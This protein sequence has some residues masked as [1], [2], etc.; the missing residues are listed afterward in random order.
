[1]DV[2]SSERWISALFTGVK[3]FV[4]NFKADER[5]LSIKVNV[6][7]PPKR[8]FL[9]ESKPLRG[10]AHLYAARVV[11]KWNY[12]RK[13]GNQIR[14]RLLFHRY[15]I[16]QPSKGIIPNHKSFLSG[17]CLISFMPEREWG[18]F[19]KSMTISMWSSFLSSAPGLPVPVSLL[20]WSEYGV[21]FKV[22]QYSPPDTG[23]ARRQMRGGDKR[24]IY[25]SLE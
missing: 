11:P 19:L 14:K 15:L 8:S 22:T 2:F 23:P 21:T 7:I 4:Y 12:S 17:F 5:W 16:F 3:N 6:G 10:A 20:F 13:V 1:M 25:N 9:E 18:L 24:T